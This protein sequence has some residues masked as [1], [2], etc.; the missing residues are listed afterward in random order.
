ML[1]ITDGITE[2]LNAQFEEFGMDRVLQALDG[3]AC[4]DAKP[5][6][7]RLLSAVDEFTGGVEQSDDITCIAVCH[8]PAAMQPRQAARIA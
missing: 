5:C 1:L 3:A 4:S 8:Q 2:A 6:I 7:E